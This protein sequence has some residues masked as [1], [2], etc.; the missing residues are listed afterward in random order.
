MFLDVKRDMIFFPFSF[1]L[2]GLMITFIVFLLTN[3]LK[4]VFFSRWP[5]QLS[6]EMGKSVTARQLLSFEATVSL[7]SHCGFHQEV[8]AA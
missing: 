8:T 3:S 6:R 2:Y 4:G 5:R 1:V 7:Y